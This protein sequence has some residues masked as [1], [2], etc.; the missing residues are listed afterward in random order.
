MKMSNTKTLV[1]TNQ[2]T[3][4]K[5]LNENLIELKEEILDFNL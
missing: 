3:C 5:K 1:H 2:F 4:F